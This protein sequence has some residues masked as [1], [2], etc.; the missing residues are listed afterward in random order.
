MVE[1]KRDKTASL[2]QAYSSDWFGK[3]EKTAKAVCFPTSAQE[4]ARCLADAQENNEKIVVRGGN[5]GLS[6]GTLVESDKSVIISINKMRDVLDYD[7][8]T[9]IVTASAGYTL[10][11]VNEYLASF[12]MFLPLHMGSYQS[13]QVGGIVA[14]NAGGMHAWKYGM[15]RNLI[16]NIECVSP[17][18]GILDMRTAS[19]KNNEGAN[20]VEYFIGSDGR[21][22]VITKVNFRTFPIKASSLGLL[23]IADCFADLAD[24]SR[25]IEEI[26]FE[27]LD[28]VE[29]VSGCSPGAE[30]VS[31]QLTH[32]KV[33]LILTF[34]SS[35]NQAKFEQIFLSILG[36][37]DILS[38]DRRVSFLN[39][40][41]VSK[42]IAAREALPSQIAE[43]GSLL[44]FDLRMKVS[45][46]DEFHSFVLEQIDIYAEAKMSFF[47]HYKDGNVHLNLAGIDPTEAVDLISSL[48]DE[49][50]R[51]GGGLSAEHGLGLSKRRSI[52]SYLSEEQ[53]ELESYL[54]DYFDAH[55]LFSLG[56]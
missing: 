8:D 33:G 46:L 2:C 4:V 51:Q 42:A 35:M 39:H 15:A 14:T 27:Y 7:S 47:G 30:S 22:G 23:L 6:G 56:H 10:L 3:I 48:N 54:C 38:N 28:V 21:I 55:R 17:S 52:A 9:Q 12:N 34:A 29:F 43:F 20:P 45:C 11:E 40:S 19:L 36:D 13:A 1:I 44:K 18:R 53:L 5:T 49:V 41:Q 37:D 16:T 31:V 50:L 32:E 24:M 26:F 25:Q